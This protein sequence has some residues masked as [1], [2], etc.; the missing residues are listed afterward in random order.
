[1]AAKKKQPKIDPTGLT[2][3]SRTQPT[4][5]F[6]SPGK[7]PTQSRSRSAAEK[8]KET[9]VTKIKN[10]QSGF[11]G[12]GTPLGTSLALSK[13]LNSPRKIIEAAGMAAG[14]GA[15][16]GLKI[17]TRF[18]ISE[19]TKKLQREFSKEMKSRSLKNMTPNQRRA[20]GEKLEDLTPEER[21]EFNAQPKFLRRAISDEMAR[22]TKKRPNIRRK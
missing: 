15:A 12:S 8:P 21:M 14:A 19:S 2:P 4:A 5:S 1:M 17:G 3:K 22:T 9:K 18:V 7:K 11:A 13:N 16:S 20:Y 10:A 6:T